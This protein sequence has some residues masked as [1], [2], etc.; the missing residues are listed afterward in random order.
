M[1]VQGREKAQLRALWTFRDPEVEEAWEV[2]SRLKPIYMHLRKTIPVERRRLSRRGELL[3]CWSAN[4]VP[5]QSTR[6]WRVF[7]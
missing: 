5:V 2:L 4:R 6:K 1:A 7:L 3:G